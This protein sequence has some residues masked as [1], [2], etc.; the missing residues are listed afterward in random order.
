V[1]SY[2]IVGPTP[3]PTQS[4]VSVGN[5]PTGAI[6]S[7]GTYGVTVLDQVNGCATS[8]TSSINNNTFTVATAQ[9]GQCDPTIAIDVTASAD[10]SPQA[11]FRVFNN[12][13]GL[14][15]PGH[16]DPGTDVD[17]TFTTLP[18]PSGSSYVVEVR[19]NTGCVASSPPLAI[20]PDPMLAVTFDRANL[21]TTARELT[22]VS[23]P[24]ATTFDWSASDA[25]SVSP[26]AGPTVTVALGTWDIVVTAT[27]P[28]GS[29]PGTANI[30]LTIDSPADVK[31]T[32]T[33]PCEDEVILTATPTG[34][35]LY[36]WFRNND[37]VLGGSTLLIGTA[38]DDQVY[39]VEVANTVTGCINSFEDEVDVEGDLQITLV[40]TT[41]CEGAPFTLT[42]GSN[43]TPV[44]FAWTLDGN[45]IPEEVSDELVETR[46]GLYEVTVSSGDACS[47]T[48]DFNI[49]LGPVT[50]GLLTDTGI[51]CP[52]PPVSQEV[53][54]DPG[55]GLISY[56]WFKEGL[57]TG[58]TTQTLIARE[59]GL[60]SVDMVNAFGC[61]SSDKIELFEECEPRITGPNAFRPG[62]GVNE[63][64]DFTNRDFKVFTFFIAD[65]D[66]HIFIFN[67]WGEMI[68]ESP[69]RD[70]RW[71]G[72]YKNNIGQP[73]PPGT[74]SYVIKYKS[75]Y[76]PEEGVH[77]KRGGVVLLR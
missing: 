41:P 16:P 67:R 5:Y 63:G 71:N 46:E 8:T 74:Y 42:A 76:R 66:F 72:G 32:Q 68:F 13:T 33:E 2:S 25:G 75:S 34:N 45:I 58:D 27:G 17:G 30:T 3:V 44:T 36:N 31:F 73:L 77:E 49:V 20:V 48:L 69:A 10:L 35:Y 21:C 56:E 1:F 38:D 12:S 18:V 65:T 14:L 50:A 9:N 4:N 24:A 47:E 28:A 6:L 55:P 52:E 43:I 7:A 51:I 60:Y 64:G 26:V 23:T 15:V 22:A 70:F 40:S 37:P 39:R 57:P 29:C 19:D 11:T 59:V 61:P 53:E 54:L 62:S